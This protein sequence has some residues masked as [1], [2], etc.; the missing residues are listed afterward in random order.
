MA[1]SV[2]MVT[3]IASSE[4]FACP[5]CPTARL[6]QASV[7]DDRF[8]KYLFL[9]SLPLLVLGAISGLLYRIGRE[10]R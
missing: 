10:G 6:V 4:A 7:F 8:W 9:I 2:W 5:D 3:M 1:R